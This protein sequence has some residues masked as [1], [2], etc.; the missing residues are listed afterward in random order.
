MAAHHPAHRT[1]SVG[2]QPFPVRGRVF[3]AENLPLGMKRACRVRAS[4]G[5]FDDAALRVV[6]PSG[7]EVS[8]GTAVEESIGVGVDTNKQPL[9]FPIGSTFDETICSNIA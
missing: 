2:E 1:Q 9:V 7:D 8:H 5:G 3:L 6:F 4:G